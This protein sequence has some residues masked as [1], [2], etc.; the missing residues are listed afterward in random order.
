LAKPGLRVIHPDPVS[1]GG[2]Q[3][4]ILSIYGSELK[5]SEAES[6]AADTNRALL[7]LQ[8]IWNNVISTPGSARE[9][10]TQS[11]REALFCTAKM[12]P[13][14]PPECAA[15]AVFFNLTRCFRK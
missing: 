7:T 11:I 10:R 6:G 14:F 5:K 9:T 12:S 2:A 8:A 3:W 1:S 4:S 13:S 15:R